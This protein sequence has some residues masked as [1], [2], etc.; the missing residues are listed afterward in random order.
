MSARTKRIRRNVS[1]YVLL[2]L[3]VLYLVLFKYV[4]IYGLQ[5]AFRDYKPSRGILQAEWVGL[6]YVHKFL[7]NHKF[8]VVMG[9][10]IRLSLLSMLTFPLPILFAFLLNYLNSDRMRRCVQMVS[11]MPHFISTVVMV[12]MI[13]QFFD[14]RGPVNQIIVSMGGAAQSFLSKKEYFDPIYIWTGVWQE[15]GY[16][17]IIYISALA[18]VSPELHEA[19]IVDGAGI[20]KRFV[21]IDLPCILPTIC[22]LLIMRCGSILNVGY[23]KIFLMQNDLNDAVS[24]VVSTFV[25]KQGLAST[26]PQYSYSTAIGLF[27]SIL[28]VLMLTIVN[29]V[30]RRLGGASL[31]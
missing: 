9:N 17:S 27:V 7:S 14:A 2:L 6:K 13:N 29:A 25:Y 4:P 12:G 1:L 23:E 31:W 19:G 5:I 10:T 15:I 20:I 16:S 22:I 8:R 18:G 26:I 11:Y 21:H 24:E 30:S 3:P 28:N